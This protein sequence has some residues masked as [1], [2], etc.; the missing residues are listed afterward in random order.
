MT[1]IAA[2]GQTPGHSA[3]AFASGSGRLLVQSDI[4]SCPELFLRD[5]DWHI[6]FDMD[7]QV[8]VQTAGKFDDMVAAESIGRGFPFFPFARLCGRRTARL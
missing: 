8:S 3:F 1:W 7:P 6:M 2:P 4:A 5:P